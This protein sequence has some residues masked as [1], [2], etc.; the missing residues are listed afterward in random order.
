MIVTKY[1]N[2]IL[3][4]LTRFPLYLHALKKGIKDAASI[5]NANPTNLKNA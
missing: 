1:N 5:V 3:G 2:K 4:V